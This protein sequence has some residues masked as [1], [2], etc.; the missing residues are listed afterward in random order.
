MQQATCKP[1]NE[2][3][4]VQLAS[5]TVLSMSL[6]LN[7]KPFNMANGPIDHECH[8]DSNDNNFAAQSGF[9]SLLPHH[10]DDGMCIIV[11]NLAF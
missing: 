9:E 11:Q 3:P 2:L 5:N 7:A 8:G 4:Q 6:A 1:T 10:S